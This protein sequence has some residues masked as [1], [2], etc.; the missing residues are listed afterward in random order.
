MYG[1]GAGMELGRGEELCPD[2]LKTGG[3]GMSF[4]HPFHSFLFPA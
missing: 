2:A 1:E 4:N 3:S